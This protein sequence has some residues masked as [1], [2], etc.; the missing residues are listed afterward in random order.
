MNRGDLSFKQQ[1]PGSIRGVAMRKMLFLLG[2]IV[3][4]VQDSIAQTAA[5]YNFSRSTGTYSSISGLSGVNVSAVT[6]DDCTETN[7][8]LGFSF[9]FCGITYTQVSACSNG[10]VSLSNNPSNYPPYPGQAACEVGICWIPPRA[11]KYSS[12]L[13]F[14][15]STS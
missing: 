9:T 10:W 11:K 13:L 7:I 5:S 14:P 2:L 6:C 12:M 15:C 8:P 1:P 3:L 4:L